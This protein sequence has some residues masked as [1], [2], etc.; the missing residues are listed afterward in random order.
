MKLTGPNQSFLRSFEGK[1]ANIFIFLCIILVLGCK[2]DFVDSPNEQALT[3][4]YLLSPTSNNF[5]RGG[6]P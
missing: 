4:D 6:A 1:N 5:V 2:K 3:D